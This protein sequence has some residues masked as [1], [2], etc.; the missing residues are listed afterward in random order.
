M[1]VIAGNFYFSN[2]FGETPFYKLPAVGGPKNM[3]G[4]YAGRYRDNVFAM[5]QLE[6][7][8]FV[9]WKF[10]F[11][12]FAGFGNV[13]DHILNFTFDHMKYSYGFGL[14]FRFNEEQKVNLR[15]DMGFG[16]DGNKGIY[17]GIEEAF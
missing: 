16:N 5:I 4:Y 8:Q 10:G 6:Y 11:V 2:A 15:M 13:A 9:W 7:R 12:A 3:R 14:R 1:K 17:F